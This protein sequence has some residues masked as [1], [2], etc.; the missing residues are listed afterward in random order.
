MIDLWKEGREWNGRDEGSE[1][2]E[3]GGEVGK[4]VKGRD[5]G[6]VPKYISPLLQTSQDAYSSFAHTPVQLRTV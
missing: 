3:G 4:R 1:G 6:D 5:E 2:I